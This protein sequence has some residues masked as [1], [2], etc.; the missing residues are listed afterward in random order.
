MG[1]YSGLLGHEP[2]TCGN[3]DG[4]RH[5]LDEHYDSGGAC[6]IEGC[7]CLGFELDEDALNEVEED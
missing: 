1:S 4:G 7:N 6:T 5:V 2:C 3:D